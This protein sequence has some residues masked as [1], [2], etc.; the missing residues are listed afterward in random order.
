MDTVPTLFPRFP[1]LPLRQ[2]D[3]ATTLLLTEEIKRKLTTALILA[4][5]DFSKPFELHCDASKVGVGTVLSQ[6]GRPIAYFS[7]KLNGAKIN[8]STYDVEF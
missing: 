6:E 2:C 3:F 1:T 8:Y 7:E 5:P 4:L